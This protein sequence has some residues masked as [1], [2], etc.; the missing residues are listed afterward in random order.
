LLDA[1]PFA[2]SL[3]VHL[4][5]FPD[6]P[7]GCRYSALAAWYGRPDAAPDPPRWRTR[8]LYWPTIRR[9]GLIEAEDLV[10]TAR[11]FDGEI[12]VV[13]DTPG[14][15][16]LSARRMVTLV[17][18]SPQARFAFRLPVPKPGLYRIA[19]RSF[20]SLRSASLY[21]ML[22]NGQRS[23]HM[24]QGFYARF[25]G[26]GLAQGELDRWGEFRLTPEANRV[27]LVPNEAYAARQSVTNFLY[28]IDG[29]LVQ[30]VGEPNRK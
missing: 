14:R 2:R 8:D 17:P 25:P 13:T 15:F 28:A 23:K 6:R 20:H 11:A 9:Q 29:F 4:A 19:T 12:N 3:D 27:V 1:V 10:A 22:V 24:F 21:E 16:F 5:R 30:S 26:V 7:A 18:Y